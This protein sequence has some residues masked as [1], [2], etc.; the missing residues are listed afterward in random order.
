MAL[1]VEIRAVPATIFDVLRFGL[2]TGNQFCSGHMTPHR[3]IP[4]GLLKHQASWWKVRELNTSLVCPICWFTNNRHHL[5]PIVY[6][7][8]ERE[9]ENQ[10]NL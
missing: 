3:A 4:I 9:R 6:T 5:L 1:V 10:T 2:L 7:R 8:S